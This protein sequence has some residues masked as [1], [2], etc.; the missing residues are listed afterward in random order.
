MN[1]SKPQLI[2]LVDDDANFREIFSAKMKAAG[3]LVETAASA[4]EGIKKAKELKPALI[5]MDIRMPDI[6]GVEA[7]G[8]LKASPET[9]D[10]KIICLSG[11]GEPRE[12]VQAV[13]VKF[14]GE[15]G[16]VSYLRKT[17]N[18][19]LLM[20][21]I[22]KFLPKIPVILLVDDDA[23]FR[24]IFSM[25]LKAAGFA[26]EL[27]EDGLGGIEKAKILKPDLILMDIKMPGI[28]GVEATSRIKEDSVTKDIKVVFLTS[29]G[30]SREEGKDIDTKM[31][32]EIGAL[33]YMR[34]TDNLDVL[35]ENIKKFIEQ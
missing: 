29:V 19:E 26:V 18:L 22:K 20:E 27:A 28:D 30:E 1:Q 32:G 6:D 31:S 24:E 7:I 23:N 17:D 12:E 4:V 5:L 21:N 16:A 13:D 11:F 10:I 25:K 8:R 33:G 9:K 3:F 14:A 34:K 2:L 15:I 35:M